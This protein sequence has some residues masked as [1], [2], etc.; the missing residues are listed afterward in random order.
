[1]Y[2]YSDKLRTLIGLGYDLRHW[3]FDGD[4]EQVPWR[5][6]FNNDPKVP[7]YV[8]DKLHGKQDVI[9]YGDNRS[10]FVLIPKKYLCGLGRLSLKNE[11][12][13]VEKLAKA[14]SGFLDDL[15][16]KS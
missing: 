4:A 8:Q 16:E 13:Y 5:V 1:M 7:E 14:V 12:K 11:D 15:Y 3:V 2:N 6:W 10:F 9:A